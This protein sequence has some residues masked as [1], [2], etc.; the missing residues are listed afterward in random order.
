MTSRT[1]CPGPIRRGGRSGRGRRGR[2]LREARRNWRCSPRSASHTDEWLQDRQQ[3]CSIPAHAAAAAAHGR[4]GARPRRGGSTARRRPR[5]GGS[6][7][8][9]LRPAGAALPSV[10]PAL[11]TLRRPS[12]DATW[13]SPSRLR[14][15]PSR[16]RRRRCLARAGSD[17]RRP[18][19][20]RPSLKRELA[21]LVAGAGARFADVALVGTVPCAWARHPR[22]RL[23]AGR[24]RVRRRARAARH[25]GGGR[26]R[27]AG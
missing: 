20:R 23:R 26:L 9:R 17:L 7:G 8:A 11:R 2:W 25:A 22:A 16:R 14:R 18:E 1:P 19:H 10:S 21:T 27:G 12:R 13:S 6:A 5:R 4:R 15:Q 3:F 24:T